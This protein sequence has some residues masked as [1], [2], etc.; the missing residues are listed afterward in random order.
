[1]SRHQVLRLAHRAGNFELF[2]VQPVEML[3]PDSDALE[4]EQRL[5]RMDVGADAVG[6]GGNAEG[7]LCESQQLCDFGG[8]RPSGI[9][10]P[11]RG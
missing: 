3:S 5:E 8:V 11:G 7:L 1:V 4:A 6:Q 9:F 10:V 2:V